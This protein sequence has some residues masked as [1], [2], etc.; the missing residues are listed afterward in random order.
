MN[1]SPKFWFSIAGGILLVLLAIFYFVIYRGTLN[2]NVSESG[3]TI[4]IDD[5]VYGETFSGRLLAGNHE[6]RIEKSGFVTL[7]EEFKLGILETKN[8]NIDLRPSPIA[9]TIQE[10]QID[11]VDFD[12]S[13]QTIVFVNKQNGQAYR[14][15]LNLDEPVF[16]SISDS[17]FIGA[18]DFSWSPD[19]LLAFFTKNNTVNQINFRRI[20][21][22]AQQVIPWPEGTKSIDWKKDNSAIAYYFAPLTDDPQKVIINI[23]QAQI[24]RTFTPVKGERSLIIADINNLEYNRVFDF[25]TTSITDPKISW[26]P[27]GQRILAQDSKL[28]IFN[29][30][31]R[32]QIES[33]EMDD[34]VVNARWL[35]NSSIIYE[36]TS[37]ELKIITLEGSV[38]DT[39]ISTSL[40]NIAFADDY[41]IVAALENNRVVF[42]RINLNDFSKTDYLLENNLNSLPSNLVIVGENLYFTHNG[43][44]Y[45]MRLDDGRYSF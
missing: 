16:D 35:D 37:G 28:H 29:P 15:S 25:K 39:G 33:L 20:N 32:G 22:V 26:S 30:A 19:K 2:V 27:D 31:I 9:Q 38:S 14:A 36:T 40:E 34:E 1:K 3:S 24:E 12:E 7:E 23:N 18:T 42:S 10:G 43:A 17:Q 21:L 44:L 6:L 45:G 41:F 8:I 5:K 4:I 11:F 13:R